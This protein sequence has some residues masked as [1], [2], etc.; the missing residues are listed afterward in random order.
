M[1]NAIT[2]CGLVLV[3]WL[4][5]CAPVSS[6]DKDGIAPEV[7]TGIRDIELVRGDRQMVSSAD[8]SASRAGMEI[9][10]AGGSATDAL[11]AMSMV[12]T[13]TE[14]Q[15]SGIGGGG[16]LVH[17]DS[18]AKAV[19]TYDGREISPAGA[20]PDQFLGPDGAPLEFWDAVV[21]G[22]SV[23]VPGLLRMLEMAHQ[24]HGKL[25]WERLFDPAIR[26]CEKGFY[27][28]P[29][30]NKL[31]AA[32][33]RLRTSPTTRA[34]FY[35]DQGE[36]LSPIRLKTNPALARVFDAVAKGGADAFYKG[37]I[38]ERL[39]QAARTAF[40][41]P[42]TMTLDDVSRYQAVER[43]ALCAPYRS[44]KVCGMG[45]PTS[46]GV[47]I[48]QI[49]GLMSRFDVEDWAPGSTELTHLFAEA[50]RL[51]YADRAL[52]LADPDVV[53]VPVA[54]LIDGDYLADRAKLISMDETMGT[55]S[56]GRPDGSASFAPDRSWEFP[57]T[58]HLVAVD[59]AGNVAN[60][61]ASIEQGFGAHIMVDGYL[62]NN[63]LTDFSFEPTR[64][65]APVANAC[66]PNKRPRSSMSPTLVF[67]EAGA[68]FMAIGSP[69]GSRIIQYVAKTLVYVLDLK[70]N[71]Q[72]AI[73][74]PHIVNRNGV[75]ELELNQDQVE[76]TGAL[77]KALRALGHE[78]VIRQQ[79]SGL[80]GVVRKSY[81]LEGGADPRREGVAIGN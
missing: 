45:P 51:A 13:L 52:Y 46:G 9:L 22:V 4:S 24:R 41:R 49:L 69:G 63:E 2:C 36:P 29:R 26:L 33:Q 14:P 23:G 40:R 12:L 57:S 56:A 62:L 20:T 35:D 38:A 71:I 47:A 58:T 15:S 19:K 53:D 61:T 80:H 16:F 8:P 77:A 37:P 81:G 48:H 17:Y 10:E 68:F 50:S 76:K 66:G 6:I 79:N 75:T 32:N 3:G 39:V 73:A 74:S 42:S 67:D 43:P 31:L 28:T 30:L 70:M 59:T 25:P 11:I 27:P 7:H 21:G 72:A 54:G 55:A 1:K 64:D 44:W 60:M 78:V 34:Y 5:G 18:N 65:G